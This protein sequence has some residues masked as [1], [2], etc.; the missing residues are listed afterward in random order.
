MPDSVTSPRRL[1]YG[2]ATYAGFEGII[3]DAGAASRLGVLARATTLRDFVAV[4]YDGDWEQFVTLAADVDEDAP[5]PDD[6]FDYEEWF[7]D[8]NVSEYPAD[9]A[10]DAASLVVMRL[11]GE[12]SEGLSGIQ[13]GGGSPGGNMGAVSG[14]LAQLAL[15]ADRIDPAKDGIVLERDDALVDLGMSRALYAQELPKSQR[16]SPSPLTPAKGTP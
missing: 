7:S 4:T 5:S 1:V 11:M 12:D 9:T 16:L 14:P 10:W 15:L 3:V 6:P 8:G 13:C 2:P